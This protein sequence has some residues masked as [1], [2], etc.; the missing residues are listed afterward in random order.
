VNALAGGGTLLTF[1]ALVAALPGASV[2]ANGTST[3]ALAPASVSSA[4]AYRQDLIKEWRWLKLLILPSL[5]GG[6]LGTWIVTSMEERYFKALIPWLIFGASLLFA[7][8]PL[9][10]KKKTV[11]HPENE[12]EQPPPHSPL[13][14]IGIVVFQFFVAVYGGYFGA[15]IGI[16]MLSGLSLIGLT[17]MHEMN[18]IKTVLA[19]CINGM[20][21][22][23]FT[24][25]HF[26][27]EPTVHWPLA[28]LMMFF[29]IVGGYLAATFGRKLKP[30]YIRWFVIVM[31]FVLSAV[32]FYGQWQKANEPVQ[33]PSAA[34]QHP[35][36]S[37]LS[38]VRGRNCYSN[39]RSSTSF[40]RPRKRSLPSMM[41][42]GTQ[43]V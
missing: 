43:L 9:L 39:L 20:S 5:I 40:T 30:I 22:V 14:L 29:G 3:V 4:W 25:K 42:T 23:I 15:G 27:S 37:S 32:F 17:N 1:P 28:F 31:G 6:I 8:Q 38:S 41:T 24:V 36:Q 2:M 35:M 34:A 7:L 21:V 19:G 12:R 33:A 11:L 16:L 18:A 10:T 13:K 26:T